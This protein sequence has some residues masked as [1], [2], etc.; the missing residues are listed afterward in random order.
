MTNYLDGSP[1]YL[2][3]DTINL[4]LGGVLEFSL[5]LTHD[6][7]LY[8]RCFIHLRTVKNSEGEQRLLQPRVRRDLG[9]CPLVG[10]NASRNALDDVS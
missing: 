9:S 10:I 1:S 3:Q 2:Q 5:L 6:L 7:E 8:F 4:V